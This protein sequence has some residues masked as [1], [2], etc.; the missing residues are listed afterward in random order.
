VRILVVNW[1]DWTHPQAGGAEIHLRETF[2]RLAGR[3]HRVDLLCVAH[4]DAPREERLDGINVIRRGGSRA[5]FNFTV[6]RVWRSALSRNGYD[7]VV[8]DMNKIPFYLPLYVDPPV[9]A[10][11]HH[12]FGRTIF[13]ETNPLFG[14]YVWLSERPIA[15]V[16]RDCPFIA[17]SP[18]TA[19]DLERR[20]VNRAGIVVIPNGIPDLA[21]EDALLALPKDPAPL[22]VYL[23]RLKRYKRV[24]LLLEAFARVEPELPGARLVIAGDGDHRAALER[25]ARARGIAERVEFPGWV[26]EEEKWR[27]LRRAW[28]VGYTSPKEGWGFSSIEAQRVG[29]IAIVSDAPGLRDTVVDGET[30]RVVPHGDVAALAEAL[31]ATAR[32]PEERG[33][34]EARAIVRA[35]TFTWDAAA[36]A[37]ES[38]LVEAIEER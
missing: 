8:D 24:E 3:G 18:S 1:Q 35:R 32:N 10:L 2:G 9:V 5:T 7:V 26:G 29:T 14:A 20:G 34:M 33:R 31:L 22:F 27:L 37:T 11:V 13:Q 17:V 38:V 15:S 6:P 16:Y 21:D 28:A 30:G 4:P 23:G 19:A 25:D 12:L 36:D